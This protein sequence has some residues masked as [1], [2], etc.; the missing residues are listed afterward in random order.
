MTENKG[1]VNAG[2]PIAENVPN[3]NSF[4]G[5]SGQTSKQMPQINPEQ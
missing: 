4:G 1:S 3:A 5:T 2:S